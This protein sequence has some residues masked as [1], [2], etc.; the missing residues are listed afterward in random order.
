MNRNLCR[1]VLEEHF[2]EPFRR[3]MVNGYAIDFY[4]KDLMIGLMYNSIHHYKYS[5]KFH[6][7]YSK[8]VA[9]QNRDKL[10]RKT[11]NMMGIKLITIPYNTE[12][13]EGTIKERLEIS[14]DCQCLGCMIDSWL[15]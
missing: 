2:K 4:N 3:T 10:R 14:N 8:F 5:P 7:V 11:C 6:K 13:V 15:I 1:K 12:C 9:S